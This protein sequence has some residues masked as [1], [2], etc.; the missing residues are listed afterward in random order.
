MSFPNGAHGKKW[1][2]GPKN[3]YQTAKI[4]VLNDFSKNL[5]SLAIIT[6][7]NWANRTISAIG[8]RRPLPLTD[9]LVQPSGTGIHLRLQLVQDVIQ[10]VV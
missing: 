5:Y 7:I 8:V 10:A 6:R 2:V 3:E 1:L 9:L 4:L